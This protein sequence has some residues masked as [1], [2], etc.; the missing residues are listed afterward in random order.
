MASDF[1]LDPQSLPSLKNLPFFFLFPLQLCKITF[2]VFS[3]LFLKQ[4]AVWL[5]YDLPH[6]WVK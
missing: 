3:S 1:M 6:S 4:F 5:I 2:F